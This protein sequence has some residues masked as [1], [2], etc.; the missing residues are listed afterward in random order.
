MSAS[1]SE[2]KKP[3]KYLD[4]FSL[5]KPICGI[6][7]TQHNHTKTFTNIF[8]ANNTVLSQRKILLETL[9]TKL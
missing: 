2:S 1:I 9:Q 7:V 8:Q 4:K 6:V 3:R 5:L